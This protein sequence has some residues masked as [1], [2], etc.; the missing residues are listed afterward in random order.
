MSIVEQPYLDKENFPPNSQQILSNK[1]FDDK[2]MVLAS[3]FIDKYSKSV[4]SSVVKQPSIDEKMSELLQYIRYNNIN[5]QE[6]RSYNTMVS[7]YNEF[8]S[9]L[10]EEGVINQGLLS[11]FAVSPTGGKG[12][13]KRRKQKKGKNTRK[14]RR[15]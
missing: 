13:T 5:L 15:P 1:V 4:G 10:T 9:C 8:V 6:N 14:R 2:K 7:C 11:N 12:L 3:K